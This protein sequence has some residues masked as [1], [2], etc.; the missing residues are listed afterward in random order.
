MT[1]L[2]RKEAAEFMS[3]PGA[4]FVVLP[5]KVVSETFPSTDASW[6]S[7]HEIGLNVAKGQN[8][9]VTMLLKTE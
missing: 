3:R 1:P 6:R 8:V 2:K 5:T 4:R 9:D 7:Y